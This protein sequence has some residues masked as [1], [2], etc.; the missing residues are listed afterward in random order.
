MQCS[1]VS[2]WGVT[3]RLVDSPRRYSAGKNK[4]GKWVSTGDPTEVALQVFAS[5]LQ[6]GRHTLTST[7]TDNNNQ[8][9]KIEQFPKRFVLKEEFPFDSDVKRMSMV[10]VDRETSGDDRVVVFLKGAVRLPLASTRIILTRRHRSNV[11]LHHAPTFSPEQTKLF[12]SLG[13]SRTL[14]LHRPRD[15][16][17][18]AC[19]LLHLLHAIPTTP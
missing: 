18:R 11:S 6:Y 5:K 1:D 14:S 15:L 12:L 13:S 2:W 4:D 10:Y 9:G 19:V 3:F 7:E 17:H 8:D 16:P